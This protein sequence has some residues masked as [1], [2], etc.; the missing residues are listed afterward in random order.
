[1]I[2]RVSDAALEDAS[3]TAL[4]LACNIGT[5]TEQGLQI[6]DVPLPTSLHVSGAAARGLDFQGEFCLQQ[7]TENIVLGRSVSTPVYQLS[8]SSPCGDG[9]ADGTTILRLESTSWAFMRS[10]CENPPCDEKPI[11]LAACDSQVLR[12]D[13]LTADCFGFR[14]DEFS[15]VPAC[16]RDAPLSVEVAGPSKG[17]GSQERGEYRRTFDLA[18]RPAYEK[19][20]ESRHLSRSCNRDIDIVTPHSKK[21]SIPNVEMMGMWKIFS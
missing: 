3:P 10:T 19:P 11:T 14:A 2:E 5:R 21:D 6:L 20:D 13:R 16:A 7:V 8:A 17:P 9:P 12:P 15:I 4:K 1:M 18:G